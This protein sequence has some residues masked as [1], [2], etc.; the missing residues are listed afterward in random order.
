VVVEDVKVTLAGLKLHLLSEGK[1]EH[2]DGKSVAEP[3][4]PFCAV[5]VRVVDPDCPGLATLIVNGL[6]VMVND[7][8]VEASPCLQINQ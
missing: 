6:A 5:N 4:K 2:I 7:G 8:V 3:V 1:F